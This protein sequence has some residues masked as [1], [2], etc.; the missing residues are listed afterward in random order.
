ML[1]QWHP[2]QTTLRVS[3]L[4]DW[5]IL[6]DFD[7]TVAVD[8]ITDTLLE[9]FGRPG[10]ERLEAD[11]RAGRIGSRECMA[12]QVA[13]LDMSGDEL[14]AHLAE[15]SIDAAFPA[16][17]EAARTA[18]MP[19]EILSDGLDYAIRTILGRY[20][21]D[22]L[23]I[24]ANRLLPAGER[25]W[26]LEFPNAS[27]ACRAASGT[28]KCA[29]TGASRSRP[30]RTV[31]IGDGASDF[32]VAEVADFVLAKGRLIEHCR[33]RRIA[34]AT[35]DG[36]ADALRLLPTLLAVAADDEDPFPLLQDAALDA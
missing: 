17:V 25:R 23:P 6:C 8:D 24:V 2:F 35:I 26:R 29:R 31:L 15:R 34:H 13:L 5:T 30:V 11:W 16:F 10:W 7:G 4:T 33:S 12:G 1:Q 27:D 32:C 36:F 21:L 28:C 18:G 20:R 14:D 19:V 3:E 22:G 9:R